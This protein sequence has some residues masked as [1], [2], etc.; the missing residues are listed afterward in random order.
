MGNKVTIDEFR[1]NLLPSARPYQWDIEFEGYPGG[2]TFPA[3]TANDTMFSFKAEHIDYGPASFAIPYGATTSKI[4]T[5]GIYLHEEAKMEQW[6]LDWKDQLCDD[7]FG[8][9]LL[10]EGARTAFVHRYKIDTS[11]SPLYPKAFTIIPEGEVAVSYT[12]EKGGQPITSELTFAVVG[13]IYV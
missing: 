3:S 11:Y 6:L 13:V 4:L 7:Q 8:V 12:S 5:V 9:A 10:K 2:K 1:K